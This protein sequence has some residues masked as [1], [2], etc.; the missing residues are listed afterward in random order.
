MQRQRTRDQAASKF[1]HHERSG[2][3]ERNP[4]IA[5]DPCE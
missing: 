5:P 4:S 2:Q 1:D 3:C